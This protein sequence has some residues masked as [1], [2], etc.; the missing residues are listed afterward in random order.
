MRTRSTTPTALP[1]LPHD[2][3]AASG[4]T[5]VSGAAVRRAAGVGGHVAPGPQS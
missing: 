2:T 4:F 5:C 3:G 1:R